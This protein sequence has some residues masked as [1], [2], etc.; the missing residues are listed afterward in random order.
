MVIPVIF[1]IF[2]RTPTVI[3]VTFDKNNPFKIDI[4]YFIRYIRYLRTKIEI[5]AWRKQIKKKKEEKDKLYIYKRGKKDES[6]FKNIKIAG[7]Y[8]I[9]GENPEK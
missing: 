5:N 7:K 1:D 4:S 9:H 2:I 3:L 6:Y 8:E